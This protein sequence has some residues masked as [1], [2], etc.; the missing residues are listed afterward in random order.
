MTSKYEGRYFVMI[1]NYTSDYQSTSK[2]LPITQAFF[3]NKFFTRNE[4]L[5]FTASL[6]R[7][8]PGYRSQGG[9]EYD[10]LEAGHRFKTLLNKGVI[11]E[12]LL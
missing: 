3:T 1:T 11:L 10:T 12:V 4:F 7:I 5:D 8:R 2:E 6:V 9:S